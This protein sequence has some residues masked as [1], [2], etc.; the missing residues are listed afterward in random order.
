MLATQPDAPAQIAV[1]GGNGAFMITLEATDN[2]GGLAVTQHVVLYEYTLDVLN[3]TTNVT[4]TVQVSQNVSVGTDNFPVLID[5]VPNGVAV[6]VSVASVN[7]AGVGVFSTQ[8]L[9]IST[10]TCGA[11]HFIALSNMQRCIV[12][13]LR[14]VQ[15]LS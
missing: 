12:F 7:G 3:A 11:I 13:A 1:L 9:T 14:I 10:S 15:S 8:N 2:D 6:Q 5:S 4:G